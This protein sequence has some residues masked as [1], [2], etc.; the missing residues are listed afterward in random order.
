MLQ[1]IG[2]KLLLWLFAILP[3]PV[4]HLI[5]D[6]TYIV[7]YHIAGYRLKV[8]R[9]NLRLAFPEKSEDELKRIE[10]KFYRH[11]ADLFVETVKFFTFGKKQVKK[12]LIV[13]N[14]EHIN[15]YFH[16]GQNII[17]SGA[18]LGN[19]EIGPLAS[20]LYFLHQFIILYKPL[21][22]KYIDREIK[23][24]RSK[25]GSKMLSIHLTARGFQYGD[26]PYCIV[27]IGDQNPSNPQKAIWVNFFGQPTATLHGIE[28][29]AKRY[30]LP[31]LFYDIRKVKRS[32]YK[33]R[34]ETLIEDPA[35]Q[36]KGYITFRY[37]QRVEQAIRE[38]PHIWLWSH[39]RWKHQY[40]PAKYKLFQF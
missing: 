14:P 8:V 1:Y 34:I 4:I 30:K 32:V 39:R 17:L 29:Y 25:F 28:L 21:K 23:R 7:L 26:K 15:N 24:L 40:D 38:K 31:V 12:H 37:M 5:A 27:M 6:L 35:Q 10:K 13:E 11:L 33:I 22:N 2:F 19:W 3:M 16:Q 36:P 20:P 9:H 18:H